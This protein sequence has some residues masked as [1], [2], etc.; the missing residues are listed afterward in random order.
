MVLKSIMF[1]VMR[2]SISEESALFLKF[3]T[4]TVLVRFKLDIK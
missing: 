4:I 1:L 3:P 2:S